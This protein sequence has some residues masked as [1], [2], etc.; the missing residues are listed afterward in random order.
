MAGPSV[1]SGKY[2][3][4]VRGS[5]G[6]LSASTAIDLDVAVEN[7][8]LSASPASLTLPV[9]SIETSKVSIIGAGGFAGT[10]SLSIS[11][12]PT[13]ISASFATPS[14]TTS[15]V[16]TFTAGSTVVPGTYTAT[17]T[18]TSGSLTNSVLVTLQVP[19]P[20]F[21]L[22]SSAGTLTV[23]SGSSADGTLSVVGANGFSGTVSLVVSGLPAGISAAFNPAS[24][25]TSSTV[26]FTA[27]ST[28]ASGT[29]T[30]TITGTSGSVTA[31]VPVT[32]NVP[33]PAQPVSY[34][35]WYIRPDGGTRYDANVPSGQCNGKYDAPYPGSGVDQNCA[36]NDF[37]YL[38]D[39]GTRGN[40]GWVIA[41][42]D[43]V[44]IEGCAAS[45][46]Q[47]NPD[48]PHC[49]IGW[50]NNQG[51]S[52][53][54][55]WCDYAPG[56]YGANFGCYN[57]PIPAGTASQPT[58]I[59]GACAV[60]GTCNS[61]NTTIRSNLMQLFGGFGDQ[62][63]LNLSG[64][65]NVDVEGLEITS[66][67][68]KCVQFGIPAYP[69]SCSNSIPGADD[70]AN[71]GILTDD[72]TSNIL[73]QDVYIHGLTASGLTGPIGGP[74]TMRRVFVGF[75]GF[76]GWNF[77]DGNDTP[78]A[79]GSSISASYVTMEGNGCD[80]QY[81]IV[82]TKFPA[83]AC[84]DDV[85][86]GFGDSWSGQDTKLA[87]FTCD[88]CQ[89][90]Y[91]TKDGFIGPHTRIANL[92]ITNSRSVGNM[93]EQW[94]WT[95]G[96]NSTTVFEN[97]LTVGNCTRM[98]Q[99]LPGAVQSF[100]AATGLPGSYLS[101]FCRA[102]GDA[103]SLSTDANS[104]IL[105]AGNT[106]VGY[107]ATVFD[108]HCNTAGNCGTSPYVFEDNII[109]G[110]TTSTNYYPYSGESPGLYYYSDSSNVAQGSYNIEYGIRNGDKCGSGG[111]LCTD[112]LLVNEPAQGAW[113]PENIFDN[114]DFHP[115]VGSPVIDAG[116]PLSGLTADYY[117]VTRPAQ[118]TIGAVEP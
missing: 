48:A 24:T 115:S 81:P 32:I 70:Y 22:S 35:T 30:A 60:T 73:L 46:N 97:N 102:A 104:S 90:L 105:I 47:M 6:S 65:Q 75:N 12:L 2:A 43:T 15:S 78:D 52:P 92:K 39:D 95:T 98:S 117:G 88:H 4:T 8:S 45:P 100:N 109:L 116:I 84:Y 91:N 42:G 64:T 69:K 83:M 11:G 94:K 36:F 80:E 37:R 50:D 62:V 34:T 72:H 13:G 99:Q 16:V 38:W 74:I 61:G 21:T 66:H 113:P 54:N 71:N 23:A 29:Y 63:V 58:R 85:S 77:D 44:V 79:A 114:F 19:A 18:G 41:G 93:G 89:Q 103:F 17:I 57:P 112:P 26:T 20:S 10:V 86:N 55:M 87:S 27:G 82:N 40:W 53:T 76:A 5:S 118:P 107:N 14:T 101:D 33:Q 106:V 56:N 3:I 9:S 111:T 68:G 67:N 1:A 31:D 96:A 49:R 7:F 25:S 28:V 108:L 51:N 59:L 110:Y